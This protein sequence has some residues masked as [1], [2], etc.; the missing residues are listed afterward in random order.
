MAYVQ[1]TVVNA[2]LKCAQ[3]GVFPTDGH[4]LRS[5]MVIKSQRKDSS[6]AE[7]SLEQAENIGFATRPRRQAIM[8]HEI[9]PAWKGEDDG[10]Q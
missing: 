10:D 7:P 6:K 8:A 3:E 9:D 5:I 1:E 4:L 2:L